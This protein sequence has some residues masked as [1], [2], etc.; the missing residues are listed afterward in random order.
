M[1]FSNET[2]GVHNL[3]TPR[4]SGLDAARSTK[5]R[6]IQYLRVN[7]LDTFVRY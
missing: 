3:M 6:T 2:L 4:S 7:I 5:A 1:K